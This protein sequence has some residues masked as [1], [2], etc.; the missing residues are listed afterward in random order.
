MS[1]PLSRTVVISI[2][3]GS[4]Q[5]PVLTALPSQREFPNAV[6]GLGGDFHYQQLFQNLYDGALITDTNSQII[7]ANQR[8]INFLLFDKVELCCLRSIDL[9][10]GADRSLLEMILQNL[11]NHQHTF[12]EAYCIRKDATMFPTDIVV[13]KLKLN[14]QDRLCFLIR[15]ITRRKQI[16]EALQRSEA[17]LRA[18]HDELEKRVEERTAELSRSNAQLV[19]QIFERRRIEAQLEQ[20]RDA[21]FESARLKSEFL[22][23][24]SHELRTP[25]NGILGMTNM[26]LDTQLSD[27]QK[28]YAQTAHDCSQ[29]L[30]Q[31]INNV[32]DFSKM[33]AG[34]L[35]I[36][37]T[38][39]D[40]R[41]QVSAV[42]EAMNAQAQSKGLHF[43]AEIPEDIPNVLRGDPDRLKHVLMSLVGNAIKFTHQGSV[44]ISVAKVLE[45]DDRIEIRFTIRD[46]GIGIS[47][48][49]KELIF[50]P[51]FQV[52]SSSTRKYGGVGLGLSISKRI[53]EK[54]G[55]SIGFETVPNEGSTFWFTIPFEKPGVEEGSTNE[56][57]VD[58]DRLLDVSD[59]HRDNLLELVELYLEQTK[60]QV[61]QL[62]AAVLSDSEDEAKRIAHSCAGSS[63]ACGM[64]AM[65]GPLRV[66]ERLA[67]EGNSERVEKLLGTLDAT[68]SRTEEFLTKFC[69][70]YDS[71]TGGV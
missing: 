67:P 17:S 2:P 35:N 48:E 36:E 28:E 60:I 18:A 21:A 38:D 39:F 9:I 13:S 46:T 22:A 41:D 70:G 52:D 23:N 31:V 27:E 26:L 59:H 5:K 65:M 56:P 51:F 58:V 49:K 62:K 32:L 42:I 1:S 68:L 50:K 30:L 14:G 69:Q 64:T 40:V 29:E 34:V 43:E 63:A 24:V 11:Q 47:E 4:K 57:L 25:M 7:D 66:L 8:A 3:P 55:G 12:I 16:E 53:I 61:Q 10:S 44:S 33:E 15:D 71:N 54:M 6:M 20:A 45:Q 37:K 19:E